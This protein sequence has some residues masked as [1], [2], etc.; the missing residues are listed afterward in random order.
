MSSNKCKH[1][2][3]VNAVSDCACRRC[4]CILETTQRNRRQPAARPSFIYLLLAVTLIGGAV[5][6]LYNGFEKSF[7]EVKAA[8]AK[9]LAAQPKP[10]PQLTRSEYDQQ[11][12]EPYKNAVANS[13]GLATSKQHTDDVNKLMQAA[14]QPAKQ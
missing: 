7:D 11:Q 6:Y 10:A 1:C 14:K 2:G 5:Y 12:A 3:I 4:G 8:E 9:R 13:P